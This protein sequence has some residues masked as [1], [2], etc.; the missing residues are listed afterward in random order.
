MRRKLTKQEQDKKDK[1]L[2]TRSGCKKNHAPGRT[3]C[4]SHHQ[5]DCA[6]KKN[7]SPF[8]K[9]LRKILKP[10]VELINYR[11]AAI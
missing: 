10:L 1:G 5:Q 8:Q 7:S 2:C 4:N 3:I 6:M 9:A 11:R